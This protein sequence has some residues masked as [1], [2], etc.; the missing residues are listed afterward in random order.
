M[1][2][3]KLKLTATETWYPEVEVPD[4]IKTND[5]ILAFISDHD[6]LD[7]DIYDWYNY[8]DNCDYECETEVMGD[9]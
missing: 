5:E 2:T 6:N 4:H 1:R 3:V 9:K 8:R 7:E